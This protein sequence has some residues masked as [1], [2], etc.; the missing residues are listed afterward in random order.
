MVL[1]LLDESDLVLSD[2]IVGTIVDEVQKVCF[3]SGLLRLK[4]MLMHLGWLHRNSWTQIQKVMVGL[5]WM[6]G[7]NM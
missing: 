5:I 3:A 2:E 1:A 6:S 4:L 7:K